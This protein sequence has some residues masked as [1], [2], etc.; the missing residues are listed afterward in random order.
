MPK[1]SKRMRQINE[2]V[3]ASIQS[4]G[5]LDALGALNLLKSLSRVK[6]VEGVDV[7]ILLGIDLRKSDQ[8]VRGFILLPKGTG[9]S[10]RVAVLAQGSKADEA[11]QAGA[12]IVGF[13]DLMERIKAGEDVSISGSSIGSGLIGI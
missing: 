13:E 1:L 8:V 5:T 4:S 11:K 3:Q 2:A 7:D 9:H 12:D 6:F 10:V